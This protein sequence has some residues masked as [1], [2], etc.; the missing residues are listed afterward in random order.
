MLTPQEEQFINYWEKT[1]TQK[2]RSVWQLSIGMP[3]AV[4]IV[5][6]LFVNMLSGWNERAEMII[7]TN[8]SVLITILIAG[9]GIVIFISYF[10]ANYRWEQNEQ[11]YQELL[12]KKKRTAADAATPLQ[13]KSIE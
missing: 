3:F 1:R 13:D 2:K 11:Q 5:L 9:L 7:R 12:A 4:F 6:A 10:S 8:S